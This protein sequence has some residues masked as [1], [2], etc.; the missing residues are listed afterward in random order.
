MKNLF[1]TIRVPDNDP[2]ERSPL[3]TGRYDNPVIINEYAWLW[4]NRDGTPTTLT[5]RVY[6]SLFGDQLTT[7]QRRHIYAEHLGIMTEYWRCHRVSAATM[8]FCGLGYSRSTTPRGQ[9][10]DNFIDIENLVYDPV[11]FKWIKPKFAPLCM[12][13]D[14]WE[15]VYAAGTTLEVPLFVINDL[16]EKWNGPVTL[17]IRKAGHLL[18]TTS[19][20]ISVESFGR[21]KEHFE[22]TTPDRAGSYELVSE[23]VYGGD[24]VQSLKKFLIK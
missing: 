7:D 17:S 19:K 5:D 1:D 10:S 22:I 14:K 16:Q 4:I 12:M 18:A 6:K 9:T 13:I 3:E 23:L 8:H 20:E 11:F 24:T 15:K 21:N 2:N